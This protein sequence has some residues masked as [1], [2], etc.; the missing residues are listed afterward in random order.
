MCRRRLNADQCLR[1]QWLKTYDDASLAQRHFTDSPDFHAS[2]SSGLSDFSD[3]STNLGSNMSVDLYRTSQ[4]SIHSTPGT[5]EESRIPEEDETRTDSIANTKVEQSYTKTETPEEVTINKAKET[6]NGK[7]IAD[8]VSRNISKGS[9]EKFHKTS[10]PKEDRTEYRY[11]SC[12]SRYRGRDMKKPTISIPESNEEKISKPTIKRSEK[13]SPT[14]STLGEKDSKLQSDSTD[15]KRKKNRMRSD[16]N[17][18]VG[19]PGIPF[20]A[21]DYEHNTTAEQRNP[22]ESKYSTIPEESDSTENKSIDRD[23]PNHA[24]TPSR[25]RI[26]ESKSTSSHEAIPSLLSSKTRV[27]KYAKSPSNNLEIPTT[28]STSYRLDNLIRYFNYSDTTSSTLT[29][30]SDTSPIETPSPSRPSSSSK[31][32]QPL[33][34]IELKRNKLESVKSLDPFSN[35][36]DI[37]PL[38]QRRLSCEPLN[39]FNYKSSNISSTPATP[40][41]PNN[42]FYSSSRDASRSVDNLKDLVDQDSRPSS[43]VLSSLSISRRGSREYSTKTLPRMKSLDTTPQPCLCTAQHVRRIWLPYSKIDLEKVQLSNHAYKEHF[44]NESSSTFSNSLANHNNNS[45]QST[46]NPRSPLLS[47]SVNC[48]RYTRPNLLYKDSDRTSFTSKTPY[49]S[50]TLSHKHRITSHKEEDDM[51]VS[52][53]QSVSLHSLKDL[54]SPT[55]SNSSTDYRSRRSVEHCNSYEPYTYKNKLNRTHCLTPENF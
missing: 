53:T 39:S 49:A 31:V 1:H 36:S 38:T 28:N 13:T 32:L 40:T 44:L 18:F 15:S 25:K 2:T 9:E 52:I 33:R 26:A 11:G 21:G 22:S 23:S 46:S 27:S 34:S 12:S 35:R 4:L 8:S 20:K 5:P 30:H 3:I 45:N 6:V 24:K 37:S 10:S 41:L 16:T 19:I 50:L 55:S 51:D 14:A 43:P 54:V 7:T 29:T 17:L 47:P 48:I 42:S